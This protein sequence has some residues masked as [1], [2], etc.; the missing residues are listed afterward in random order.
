MTFVSQ[1]KSGSERL[2]SRRQ[3]LLADVALTPDGW[4]RNLLVEIES[5]DGRIAAIE[6]DVAEA[7]E[8]ERIGIL[9]PAPANLHSHAFQRAMAGLTEKRGWTSD[10]F[11][12]WRSLMYRFV[13]LLTPEDIE[14]IAAMVQME[15]LEAGYAAIGEFHYLHHQPN[16]D[17]YSAPGELTH[18]IFEATKTTGIGLTHLPVLYTQ[19]GIDGRPLE[20]GQRR[21]GNSLDGFEALLAD[22]K[23]RLG[24]L[25]KDCRLGGA[26]HSLRAA[27]IS[28][29]KAVADFFQDGPLHIHIAEQIREV[30]EVQATTG[31]RPLHYLFD[32]AN[33]DHRWCLIHA[34]HMDPS[35][36]QTLA[37]SGAVVG[38][39][40]ITEASLGDGIFQASAFMQMG[41][42][43]GIGTDSNIQVSLVSELQLLEYGQRLRDRRRAVLATEQKSTGRFLFDAACAGGAQALHR[44]AGSIEIGKLADLVALDDEALA[45]TGL[46]DDAIL[47]AWIFAD[48]DRLVT[49]VWSAG[50]HVVTEGRHR[51]RADIQEKARRVMT[52][53]R[54]AL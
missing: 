13:E 28:E 18:R 36:T 53:L 35:E 33:V 51:R 3:R 37:D 11:W 31:R 6:C 16:G 12:T 49:D 26:P 45:L 40:P 50:R 2:P 9:L 52:K 47:D 20:G 48:D 30:E 21:F 15:T 44:D 19:G 46:E 23:V 22:I 38:V 41:G 25:P 10:S 34:T 54:S 14:A 39:C 27:A 29:V 7:D 43:I 1:I 8:A 17:V 5:G 32:H 24:D 42:R 4:R